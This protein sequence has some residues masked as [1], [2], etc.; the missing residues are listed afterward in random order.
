MRFVRWA[1]GSDIKSWQELTEWKETITIRDH[2]AICSCY[3]IL[4][5]STGTTRISGNRSSDFPWTRG[6]TINRRN[7]R[8]VVNSPWVLPD[9]TEKNTSRDLPSTWKP[10]EPRFM[11]LPLEKLKP[12]RGDVSPIWGSESRGKENA[13]LKKLKFWRRHPANQKQ[14]LKRIIHHLAV[15][16]VCF[17]FYNFFQQKIT[18]L[19]NNFNLSKKRKTQPPLDGGHHPWPEHWNAARSLV[20]SLPLRLRCF[21][22]SGEPGVFGR[23][24]AALN[25]NICCCFFCGGGGVGGLRTSH[26]FGWVWEML[27]G[28]MIYMVLYMFVVISNDIQ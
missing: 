27:L 20:A 1:W 14:N 17:W 16:C 2:Q 6:N 24:G 21:W 28:M 11:E 26:F 8:V 22:V 25:P 13:A 3:F 4:V 23:K 7:R 15:V 18:P 12:L 10:K 19:S 9:I 5:S